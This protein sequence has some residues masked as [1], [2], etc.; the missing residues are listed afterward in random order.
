[1]KGTATL[2]APH[3]QRFQLHLGGGFIHR[4][5]PTDTNG[6]PMHLSLSHRP[7]WYDFDPERRPQIELI[8][9]WRNPVLVMDD[10]GSIAGAFLSDGTAYLGPKEHQPPRG[11]RVPI[12]LTADGR[13][14]FEAACLER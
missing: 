4:R 9:D 2:C 5:L 6:E 14:D 11:E 1:V 8:G 13:S 7:F 10:R 3:G 12:T